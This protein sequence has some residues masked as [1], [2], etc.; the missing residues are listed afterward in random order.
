MGRR[1]HSDGQSLVEVGIPSSRHGE[2][3]ESRRS[4]PSSDERTRRVDE[5]RNYR[6]HVWTD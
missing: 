3:D 1:L 5:T 6:V 2:E 4:P